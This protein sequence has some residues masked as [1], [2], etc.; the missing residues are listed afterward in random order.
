M[1]ATH[2][3]WSAS[4]FKILHNM[5]TVYRSK[6]LVDADVYSTT[7]KSCTNLKS[8]SKSMMEDIS[9]D[10][11]GIYDDGSEYDFNFS[12]GKGLDDKKANNQIIPERKMTFLE[13]DDNYQ[14]NDSSESQSESDEPMYSS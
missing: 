9:N 7:D 13:L 3:F 12:L 8:L 1:Y 2:Y 11:D 6:F 10:P 5:P 4:D 14:F